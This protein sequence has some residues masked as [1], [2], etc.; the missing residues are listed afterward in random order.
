MTTQEFIEKSI[1]KHGNKYSYLLVDYENTKIKTQIIC[2]KPGHKSFWQTPSDHLYGGFGCPDCSGNRQLITEEFIDKSAVKHNNQF[3]YLLVDY[4]N[5]STKIPIICLVPEH[6]VFEQTPSHH[7]QGRGCPDC[8]GNRPSTTEAFIKKATVTH[9]NTYSYLLVDYS[10]NYA[11]IPI[12]CLI[13]GHGI[14][15]Q[16]AASHLQGHGCPKCSNI[17]SQIEIE[18]LEHIEISPEY[19]Q[20][21]I[22]NTRFKVDGFDPKTNTVFEFLGLVW[23]GSSFSTKQLFSR[24]ESWKL[25]NETFIRFKEL[26]Q[27]GYNVLYCWEDDW[28]EYKSN[29]FKF[30]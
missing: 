23:H 15:E 24:E 11:K 2:L 5:S 6:G 8:S 7:L 25:Y 12:I 18:W 22:P 21:R 10:N 14:F 27:F 20:Y 17:I 4:T 28:L 1:A 19:R 3:S 26:E 29:G 30:P 9:N 13:L 16:E